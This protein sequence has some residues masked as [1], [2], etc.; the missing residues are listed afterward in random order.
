LLPTK[1]LAAYRKRKGAEKVKKQG[2]GAGFPNF[3]NK[4]GRLLL[5]LL[6]NYL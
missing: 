5:I 3:K 6:I 2:P 1:P 4:K